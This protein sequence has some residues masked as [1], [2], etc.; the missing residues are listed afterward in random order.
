MREVK[1]KLNKRTGQNATKSGEALKVPEEAKYVLG[2]GKKKLLWSNK[3][4]IRTKLWK[5]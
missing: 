2:I 3:G 1:Q 5:L 4:L